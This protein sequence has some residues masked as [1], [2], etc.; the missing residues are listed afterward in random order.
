MK[1]EL[2]AQPS[3]EDSRLQ[4]CRCI[5]KQGY[6]KSINQLEN[7]HTMPRVSVGTTYSGR[8][9]HNM[10]QDSLIVALRSN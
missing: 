5:P 3:R 1:L 8:H 9:S 2:M 10:P 7:F 4:E 6:L